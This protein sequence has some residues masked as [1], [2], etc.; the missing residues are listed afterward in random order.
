MYSFTYRN[1]T[2][3]GAF[4]CPRLDINTIENPRRL[5]KIVSLH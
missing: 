4:R 3:I 2:L 5:T 1:Q